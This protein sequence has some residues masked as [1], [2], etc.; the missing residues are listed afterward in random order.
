MKLY[1]K[2][3]VLFT[4]IVSTASSCE[5][6][7]VN[8]M[9]NDMAKFDRAFIPVL[10][11]VRNGEM[12]NAKR[13]VFF[14]NHSW[15]QFNN[16]YKGLLPDSDDWQESFRK[17]DAWLSDAYT[18][19]DANAPLESYIFLDHVRYQ[20]MDIREQNEWEYFLDDIWEFEARIDLVEEVAVDQ[21]MCLLDYCEFEDLVDDMNIA[22]EA[23]QIKNEDKVLF[24]MDEKDLKMLKFNRQRLEGAIRAFN[25]AVAEAEGENLAIAAT[26]L[27]VAYLDY[28]SSFGDFISSKSYFASI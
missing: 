24:D 16:K 12:D 22:W 20:L 6:K 7:N 9:L 18:S 26:F 15:Q 8:V 1:Y 4:L 21:M 19:I 28:M 25:I 10:F 17:T 23:I 27:Q 13:S 2:I 5:E 3:L 14:L 11:Y